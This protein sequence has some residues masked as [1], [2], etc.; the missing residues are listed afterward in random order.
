MRHM[1]IYDMESLK[2]QI[3]SPLSISRLIAIDCY[4]DITPTS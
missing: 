2:L 1:R 4:V 3:C